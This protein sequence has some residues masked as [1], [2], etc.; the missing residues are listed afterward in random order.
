MQNF[1]GALGTFDGLFAA[2]QVRPDFGVNLIAGFPVEQTNTGLQTGRQF[3]SVAVP[4]TPVGKH[5]DASLFYTQWHNDG[6]TDREAVGTQARLLLP[7]A[8]VTALLDY[9]IFYQS[10]NTAAIL[11]TMQLPALWN[12]SFDAERRNAPVLTTHNA[13]IGRPFST[14][15]ELAKFYESIGLPTDTIYQN[16]RDNTSSS[17]S[18]SVTISRPLGPR[19]QFAATVSA[20]EFGPTNSVGTSVPAQA[21][22]GLQT[23]YQAQIY[24]SNIW[25]EGDFNVLSVL[26]ADTQTA[27]TY[28]ASMTERFPV[29]A[30]WRLGPRLSVVHQQLSSDG[31]N[32]L[33]LLPS[34][35]LDWQRGRNLVQ[36]EGGYEFG[37]RDSALQ[38]QNT[39]RY[40]VSLSYRIAF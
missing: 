1:D 27:K 36:I 31:S 35:L 4:Y 2:W 10:L 30:A 33:S 28:S 23:A 17:S 14:L 39:R 13:L 15:D 21:A 3:W 34:A 7:K 38:T 26:Y 37:K 5:W 20:Q 8:S 22:T 9:D 25:K 18:Y 12:V 29:G 40:Y 11:G 19:Y 24:G 32:Q 6:F 16:A